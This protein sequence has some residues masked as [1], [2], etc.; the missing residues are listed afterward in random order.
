MAQTARKGREVA[1]KGVLLRLR[2]AATIKIP[3]IL[4]NQLPTPE[5]KRKMQDEC[6]KYVKQMRHCQWCC[7]D[8]I[9][10]L[11]QDIQSCIYRRNNLFFYYNH[12]QLCNIKKIILYYFGYSNHMFLPEGAFSLKVELVR[13]F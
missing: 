11:G 6:G 12:N 10:K 3:M 13:E 7:A 9:G 4:L 1:P 2:F 8:A 5:M